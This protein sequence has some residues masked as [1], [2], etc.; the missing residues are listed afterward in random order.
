MASKFTRSELGTKAAWKGF[1]SQTS[2]I[3]YRL[4]LLNDESTFFPE[5]AEDLM[6]KKDN[7]PQELVQVKNLKA[8]LALSHLSPQ[9]SDSFFRR[10]LSYKTENSDLILKVVSYGNIGNE[11]SGFI[12]NDENSIK[13]L[14]EKMLEY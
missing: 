9:E 14:H 4:M 6:I 5:Q 12:N 11:L 2:Y 1:S 3:A 13:S 8:D 7:I 10:C